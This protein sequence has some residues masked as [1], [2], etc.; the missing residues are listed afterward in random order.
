M[1]MAKLGK[2]LAFVNPLDQSAVSQIVKANKGGGFFGQA[3]A[4]VKEGA[5]AM[6]PGGGYWKGKTV[7][8]VNGKLRSLTPGNIGSPLQMSLSREGAK[9]RLP[10][11]AARNEVA[12]QRKLFAGAVGAWAGL[13]VMAPDSSLT[14]AANM[15]AGAAGTVA[16][17][18][19]V[20]GPRWG[21]KAAAGFYAGMGGLAG[22]K[23]LGIL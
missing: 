7:R 12:G 23:M 17:G 20:V 8:A 5:R 10:W 18:R 21:P 13:N 15:V 11:R 3:A 19:G 1:G 16:L 14:G 9:A 4:L 6:A 2:L 22:A